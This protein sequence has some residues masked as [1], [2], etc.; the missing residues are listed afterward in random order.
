MSRTLLQKPQ[1]F[2][3][4]VNREL[5]QKDDLVSDLGYRRI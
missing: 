2:G 3:E 4:I 5:S 1:V